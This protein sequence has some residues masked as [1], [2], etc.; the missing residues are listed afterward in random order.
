[1]RCRKTFK[2]YISCLLASSRPVGFFFL[3]KPQDTQL[4]WGQSTILEALADG[5]KSVTYTW[6]KDG[7]P[8]SLD[9]KKSIVGEG[10]LKL[11]YVDENDAG[12]YKV[13]ANSD[14]QSLEASASLSVTCKW[15]MA[16]QR[17]EFFEFCLT[18][19]IL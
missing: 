15:T 5:G 19:W 12:V 13:V 8:I 14:G 4:S 7:Q 9:A 10:N 1:M 3:G 18:S 17:V 11:L 6:Y 2:N 16:L